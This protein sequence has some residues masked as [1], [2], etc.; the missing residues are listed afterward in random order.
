MCVLL[1]SWVVVRKHLQ[2]GVVLRFETKVT[3]CFSPFN[4]FISLSKESQNPEFVQKAL[5]QGF[6]NEVLD[7]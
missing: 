3:F 2:P 6:E 1:Q 7:Y 4:H 5:K